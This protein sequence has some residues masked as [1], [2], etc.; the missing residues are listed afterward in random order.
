MQERKKFETI[1]KISEIIR[2]TL[3]DYTT[4]FTVVDLNLPKKGG[5]MKIFLSIFPDNKEKEVISF[6]NRNSFKIREEIVER[7]F[8]RYLPRKVFFYPSGVI[9]EATKVLELIDEISEKE[10]KNSKTK[11][12]A[13]S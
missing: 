13:K 8:L 5:T 10:E 12:R 3:P 11:K 1:K 4:I 9:R 7:V 6:L 2:E